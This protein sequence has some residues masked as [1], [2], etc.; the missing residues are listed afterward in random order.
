MAYD[1]HYTTSAPG[2][3]APLWWVQE[4]AQYMSKVMPAEKVLMGMAT[5]GYDWPK[6]TKATSVTAQK[7][8]QLRSNYQV[9][10]HWDEESYSPY[11]TYWDEQGRC[12]EVWLENHK[13]LTAKW[14]VVTDYNLG[15]VSFWRI[16]TGFTDLYQVLEE[17]R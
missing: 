6:N 17:Q 9:Q 4:V 12:H 11:Y 1:Y 13:S 15:G 5:Y 10:S 2:A 7:L 16:G 8:A 14:E 3:I